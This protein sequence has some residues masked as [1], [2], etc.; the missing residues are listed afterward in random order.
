MTHLQNSEWKILCLSVLYL[1]FLVV[2]DLG[3]GNAKAVPTHTQRNL[4]ELN[5]Y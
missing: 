4:F 1:A 2:S 3:E 5:C